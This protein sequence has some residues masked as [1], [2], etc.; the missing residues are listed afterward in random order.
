MRQTQRVQCHCGKASLAE[1]AEQFDALVEQIHSA[2]G[3]PAVAQHA[4]QPEQGLGDP[5]LVIGLA[6][7]VKR[8]F[9]QCAGTV[10]VTG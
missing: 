3:V 4:A 1:S 6:A 10:E 9:V 7:Q 8:C 5:Q 2:L